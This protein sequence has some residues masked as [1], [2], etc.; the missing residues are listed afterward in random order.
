MIM[1]II[2]VQIHLLYLHKGI[3][4]MIHPKIKNLVRFT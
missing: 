4:L 2:N 1:I 3:D